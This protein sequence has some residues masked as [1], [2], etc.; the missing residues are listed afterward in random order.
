MGSTISEV[1]SFIVNLK[2]KKVSYLKK[3][4]NYPPRHLLLPSGPPQRHPS[5]KTS[6]TFSYTLEK[7]KFKFLQIQVSIL[8]IA[9]LACLEDA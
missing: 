3:K 1:S 4:K 6:T 7:R 9:E 8:P 2:K 5:V